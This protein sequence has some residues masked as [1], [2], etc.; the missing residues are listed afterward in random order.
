[1]DIIEVKNKLQSME[2]AEEKVSESLYHLMEEPD[3]F[4][5]CDTG[6]DIVRAVMSCNTQEE[7]DAADRM[8]IAVTNYGLELILDNISVIDRYGVWEYE[9]NTER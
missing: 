6:R 3:N 8:L 2:H 9:R 7:L 4:D 5:V 1:M